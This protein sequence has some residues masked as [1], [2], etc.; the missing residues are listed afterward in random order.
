MDKEQIYNNMITA[1]RDQSVASL[2]YLT[3]HAGDELSSCEANAAANFGRVKAYINDAHTANT[4]YLDEAGSMVDSIEAQVA[5]LQSQTGSGTDARFATEAP[6]PTPTPTPTWTPT[7]V[8]LFQKMPMAQRAKLKMLQIKYVA[9]DRTLDQASDFSQLFTDI[10]TSIQSQREATNQNQL[11]DL[12]QAQTENDAEL[13]RCAT[14]QSRTVAAITTRHDNLQSEKGASDARLSAAI[15]VEAAARQEMNVACAAA[16]AAE[17]LLRVQIPILQQAH[18]DCDTAADA[19]YDSC[20]AAADGELQTCTDYLTSERTTVQQIQNINAHLGSQQVAGAALLQ[21][22]SRFIRQ[23]AKR[24]S[25][26]KVQMPMLYT[27]DLSKYSSIKDE[28][29]ALITDMKSTANSDITAENAREVSLHQD[30]TKKRNKLK[31]DAEAALVT[32]I[33][34]QDALVLAAKTERDAK[35]FARRE[36]A[37]SSSLK[38][39]NSQDKRAEQTIARLKAELTEKEQIIMQLE[40]RQLSSVTEQSS[41]LNVYS[42]ASAWHSW[43]T[44]AAVQRR[45]VDLT[46]QIQILRGELDTTDRAMAAMEREQTVSMS[47]EHELEQSLGKL[48]SKLSVHDFETSQLEREQEK[49]GDKVEQSVVMLKAW[50]RWMAKANVYKEVSQEVRSLKGQVAT[51]DR[52]IQQLK[53]QDLGTGLPTMGGLDLDGF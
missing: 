50:H 37:L 1:Q 28:I 13:A 38:Q 23:V 33:A 36:Q 19:A 4:Q 24:N 3:A 10:R 16:D 49:I 17:E 2:T 14:E 30:N 31:S 15:N 26:G 12:A 35:E 44:Q 29:I 11:D 25:K 34:E 21:A 8:S 20:Q 40:N 6:V 22:A 51:K 48:Q 39:P 52:T 9:G 43:R 18:D 32:C 27:T 5:D 46:M 45:L 53:Q 41:D 42:K 7:P 47:R